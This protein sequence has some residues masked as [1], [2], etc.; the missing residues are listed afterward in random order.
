[1]KRTYSIPSAGWGPPFAPEV[2]QAAL[3]ALEQGQVLYF[4]D[5]VFPL[6]RAEERLLDPAIL[7]RSKNVSYDPASGKLGG[8]VCRGPEAESLK[9]L[10]HRYADAALGLFQQLLPYGT[11]L[12]RERT[13]LRPAAIAERVT[14]WRKD[15]KLLHVDSFPSSPVQGRRILRLF[16]NINPHGQPR[17]WRVGEPFP[18]VAGRFWPRMAPPRW[19]SRRALA[20]LGLTKGM[21]SE[22]D[23]Y[24]LQIHDAMKAD[25]HYQQ[26][27]PQEAFDF[28]AGSAWGCF[29]DQVSHA[30]TAGQH[31]LEQTFTLTV[32]AMQDRHTAPLLVLEGLAGRP[33]VRA[34][35]REAA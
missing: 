20:W 9:G 29:T 12:R 32:E 16:C 22:Y 28:P 11:A 2:R 7:T 15:D 33:L 34:T 5:L 35:S 8:T 13:S 17:R 3:R 18:R 30:A 27:A 1:M 6:S 19:L 10:L 24:M 26:N 4:P 14:S 25:A 23:H 21:R 31:Q